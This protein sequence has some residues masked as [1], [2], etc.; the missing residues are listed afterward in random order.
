MP[1]LGRRRRNSTKPTTGAPAS[2]ASRV[3]RR[4]VRRATLQR[5]APQHRILGVTVDQDDHPTPPAPAGRRH[6]AGDRAA[7]RHEAVRVAQRLD[8][9]GGSSCSLLVAR[10]SGCSSWWWC[11]SF[12][13]DAEHQAHVVAAEA[14]RVRDR[15]V[16][17]PAFLS[18][19]PG[20]AVR[21]VVEVEASSGSPWPAS[22]ARCRA[23]ARRASRPPR[24]HQRRRAGDR[25]PTRGGRDPLHRLAQRSLERLGLR[26]TFRAWRCRRRHVVDLVGWTP[27]SAITR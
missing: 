24:P 14:E 9:L 4:S 10:C 7:E 23:R 21:D 16:T 5:A 26:R 17:G 22:A 18:C 13:S 8:A 1:L 20:R 3:A 19:R 15:D 11:R 25:S 27:A 2:P 12:A 6:Q